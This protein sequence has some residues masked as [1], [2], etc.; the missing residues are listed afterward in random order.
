MPA[1]FERRGSIVRRLS[2]IVGAALVGIV[3]VVAGVALVEQQRQLAR[4]LETKATSL[5]QFMAEVSPLS[6]LSLNF[7]EMSN[8]VKKV[9]VTDDEAV[10]AIMLN[11][12][13]IPLAWYFKDND[14]AVTDEVR[15][16]ETAR[17]PIAGVAAMKRTARI[18]E[19][20]TPIDAGGRRIGWA[21]VGFSAEPMHRALM[22]QIAVIGAILVVV[23]A[24]S[25]ALIGYL[26]R[27]MLQPI[28]TLTSA[29]MQISTGNLDVALTGTGRSDE[30]GVLARAFDSMAAQLRELI[31]GMEQRMAELQRMSHALQKSEEQFRRIVATAN[32]GIGVIDAE[33]RIT[34]ANARMSEML[35]LPVDAMQGRMLV[36]FMHEEDVPD[37]ERRA[38]MRAQG[39]AET[40]ERRFRR[41]DGR[42]AWMLVSATPVMDEQ[43]RY[44]GAFGMF[45]DI[46]ARK[47]AEDEIRRFNQQLE[48]RVAQR[49]EQL[50]AANHELEAFSYSVSHD[51][52]A[53]LR[54]IDGYSHILLEDYTDKLDDEGRRILRAVSD[55]TRRMGQLID[56]ILKFSRSGRSEM[57]TTDIDM[58]QLAREALHEVAPGE[59]P[60]R[61]DI[62]ALPHVQGDRAM[63][64]QVFVNLLANA[65]KFSRSRAAPRIV[66]DGTVNGNEAV[67]T[68]KDNGV[69]FDDR[70]VD[71]LFGVFQRL[72]GIAEFEGTGIGLAIVKRI[73]SRHGGRVWA[74]GRVGEGALIGFA[75]P[76]TPAQGD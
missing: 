58:E 44:A 60:L 23:T 61:V 6:I 10:Y 11:D 64:R 2:L 59:G 42:I 13:R 12:R 31:A 38:G 19:V 9:V 4:A 17:Q 33:G 45:T 5:A 74:E 27:R 14:P 68:V 63:L 39:V 24:A 49:T 16:L 52:R 28:R 26:L 43:G 35:G 30:L 22:L 1:L 73:V 55:S 29:A 71:K 21:V 25:L 8:N 7:V 20:E 53:P 69:G 37:H 67:Y 62:G 34:F 56:D 15:A 57:A 72:H 70:Q 18:L 54:A 75:L 51:L 32:E 76:R 36:D 47:Q 66:V 65:V 46:T 41:A 3:L 40:Y 48:Q 50:E